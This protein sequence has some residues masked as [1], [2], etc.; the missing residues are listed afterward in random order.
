MGGL[1]ESNLVRIPPN[2]DQRLHNTS[3][4]SSC[5]HYRWANILSQI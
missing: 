5:L 3:H 1:I 4:E 2:S